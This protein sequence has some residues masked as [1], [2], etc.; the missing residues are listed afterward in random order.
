VAIAST[1]LATNQGFKSLVLKEGYLPEFYFYVM[2]TK[3]SEMES[4]AGGSTFKEISGRVMKTIRV[5]VPPLEEQRAVAEVLGALDDRIEW[6]TTG[7]MA[8][9]KIVRI[10]AEHWES[11]GT[12]ALAAVASLDRTTVAAGELREKFWTHYSIP[13]FDSGQEPR[14]EWGSDIK[15]GKFRVPTGSVLVSKLNPTWPR[16]WLPNSA[17]GAP[18]ICST[19]FMPLLPNE[20]MLAGTAVLWASL[21]SNAFNSQLRERASGST[22]S[23]QRVRPEDILSSRVFDQTNISEAEAYFL[24][25][26]SEQVRALRAERRALTDLRDVLVSRLVSGEMLIPDPQALLGPVG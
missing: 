14:V 7:T 15:S 1:P 9:E 20:A 16:V 23:H 10:S 11:L 19:E 22:G 3:K 4:V 2:K 18:A 25:A 13:S 5:P 17:D 12:V 24:Q 26:L 6:C 21:L 8:A